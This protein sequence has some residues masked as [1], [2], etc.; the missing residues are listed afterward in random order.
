MGLLFWLQVVGAVAA[1]FAVLL[2][3]H[4]AIG[5]WHHRR[6]IRDIYRR[7]AEELDRVLKDVK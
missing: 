7:G 2:G 5:E 6:R 3:L 1:W 4:Y